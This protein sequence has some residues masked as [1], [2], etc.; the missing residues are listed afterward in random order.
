MAT[1]MS[2]DKVL[3]K[4]MKKERLVNDVD[5][6]EHNHHQNGHEHHHHQ[7]GHAG[8]HHHH[9]NGDHHHHQNHQNNGEHRHHHHHGQSHIMETDDDDDEEEN[10]TEQVHISDGSEEEEEED[11]VNQSGSY[12][13]ASELERIS[14]SE[15]TVS[16]TQ[17]DPN[18]ND[19]C[20]ECPSSEGGE[21]S[22]LILSPGF[23]F[24][25]FV[26]SYFIIFHL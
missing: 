6:I 25:I 16:G 24:E 23:D 14:T 12:P 20:N 13:P 8:E 10:E 11:S 2:K 9:Q 22:E 5:N 19:E 1:I 15:L 21:E 3:T 26:F 4:K 7:S 17:D 18:G